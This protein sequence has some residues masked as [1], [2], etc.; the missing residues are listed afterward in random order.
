MIRTLNPEGKTYDLHFQSL[1]S[2]FVESALR[3]HPFEALG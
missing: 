2:V 1:N 3:H